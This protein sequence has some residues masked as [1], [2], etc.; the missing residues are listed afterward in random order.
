M[1][2]LLFYLKKNLSTCNNDSYF[3]P[4]LEEE[5][6][7]LESIASTSII[8]KVKIYNLLF[9]INKFIRY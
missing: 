7:F 4:Y 2:S 5:E 6:A 9:Y 3:S 1:V 8:N